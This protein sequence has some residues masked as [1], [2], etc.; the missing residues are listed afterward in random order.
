MLGAFEDTH[1]RYWSHRLT[2]NGISRAEAKK[3]QTGHPLC[4][5][6]ATMR[7]VAVGLNLEAQ[8]TE[9]RS[10]TETAVM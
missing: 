7:L 9:P 5:C 4:I 6:G 2:E 8:Y 1:Q 3:R 10:T